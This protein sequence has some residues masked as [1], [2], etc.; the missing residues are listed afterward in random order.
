VVGQIR[1]IDGGVDIRL[2]PVTGNN[3]ALIGTF[4]YSDVIL[5][6]GS[7]GPERVRIAASNGNVGIGTSTPAYPLDVNGTIRATSIISTNAISSLYGGTGIAGAT[8][9][10]TMNT[11]FKSLPTT[12]P[13]TTNQP[14][15]NGGSLSF[16]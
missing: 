10:A 2:V 4:S 9:S 1:A 8:F 16:T 6:A 11:W 5:T 12:L 14:W 13:S 3:T 15:N 7:G